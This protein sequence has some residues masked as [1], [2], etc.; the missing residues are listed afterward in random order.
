M[1]TL[2][3][4]IESFVYPFY[5]RFTDMVYK[6]G[7]DTVF[8]GIRVL[9]DD[10]KFTHG[11]L[12]NAAATLYVHY[13]KTNDTRADEVLKRL[14][15]FIMIAT[16]NVC[17]TWGKIAILRAFNTLNKA[18]LVGRV[19]AELAERVRE[20]TEYDDFFDKEKL[21]TR[22]MATNYMQVAMACAG[23]RESL[24]WENGGYAEKIKEKLVGI[25]AEKAE[26]G[27]LDD[28]VPYGRFD[29]YSV[30][31]PAEFADTAAESGL[32]VPTLITENLRCSTEALLFMANER[33]DGVSYGRSVACHGDCTVV[34]VLSSAFATG[35]I[36]ESER[37]LALAYS[38][39]AVDKLLNFW[40]DGEAGCFNMWWGG[41]GTNDYRPI[42]RI[43]ET[44]LDIANHLFMALCNF[45][46][47]G[48]ADAEC[49]ASLPRPENWQLY[50]LTFINREDNVKKTLIMRRDDTLLMLPFVGLGGH[51]G[52][53]CS[54][55]P[56]P[57][58]CGTL[59]SS[60]IAL[61]PFMLPEYKDENGRSY[62]PCQFFDR[63]TASNSGDT[64][65]AVAEGYLSVCDTDTPERSDARFTLSFKIVGNKVDMS[66]TAD[67][68]MASAEMITASCQGNAEITATGFDSAAKINTE[69][70][71]DFRGAQGALTDATLH[72][73]SRPAT[74]GYTAILKI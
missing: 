10:I 33:G 66:I 7:E 41:R 45:E 17:K 13:V 53:R 72:T 63:V 20:K 52:K 48:V 24:G 38:M 36:K 64:V 54:Y 25:L 21:D 47:A 44:N 57:A 30:V 68:P 42:D 1:S 69:E 32:D 2:R 12:V 73:V 55:Y 29:R 23:Y 9:D 61:Y 28:E 74:L 43:L 3:T 37:E 34:E 19:D 39:R 8:R 11:A 67:K 6:G 58:V 18:G 60:Q 5:E 70:R 62:R 4:R 40:Y 51:M 27:W 35:L 16:E 56:F 26:N 31:L 46:R 22:G 14:N 49:S 71:A 65:T 15:Y 59:E 50:D